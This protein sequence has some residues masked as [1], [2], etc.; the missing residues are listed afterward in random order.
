MSISRPLHPKVSIVVRHWS[1]VVVQEFQDLKTMVKHRLRQLMSQPLCMFYVIIT[2][3]TYVV[4]F[5]ALVN[6]NLPASVPI[7]IISRSRATA[8]HRVL[9]GV[10]TFGR[11]RLASGCTSIDRTQGT[12][13]QKRVCT[14]CC[15]PG[16]AAR[17]VLTKEHPAISFC[18][19]GDLLV[20]NSLTCHSLQAVS[21]LTGTSISLGAL[22][23]GKI[24]K[25]AI[26]TLLRPVIVS[27]R[28]LSGP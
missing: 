23:T 12:V 22:A 7:K 11:I 27:A 10:S 9:H 5:A 18:A 14:F 17:G 28:T 3:L 6:R 25:G 16:K 1:S 8:A 26:V 19:G 13:R 4:F 2:P 15:V 21:I 20:T 24:S